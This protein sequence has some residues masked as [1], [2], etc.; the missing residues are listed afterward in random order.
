MWADLGLLKLMQE[1]V[2]LMVKK[3]EIN[4]NLLKSAFLRKKKKLF[5]FPV[6]CDISMCYANNKHKQAMQ[7]HVG[8]F[9]R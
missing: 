2:L 4:E 6:L 5:C 8:S 7:S 9:A 3:V 1:V